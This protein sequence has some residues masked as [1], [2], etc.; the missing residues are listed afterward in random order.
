MLPDIDAIYED[1]H[2]IETEQGAFV[3]P[4]CEKE[5]KRRPAA[6]KHLDK[7]ECHSALDVFEGTPYEE[8]A[9]LFYKN[10]M[11]SSN[12]RARPTMKSFRK[13]RLYKQ[14]NTYILSCIINEVDAGLFYSF[15]EEIIGFRYTNAILSN[16]K[17]DK[18]VHEFRVF[19]HANPSVSGSKEFYKG[20]K[21]ELL[22][23]EDYL[24]RSIAKA[25][26]SIGFI[27]QRKSLEEAVSNFP[28]GY[29]MRILDIMNEVDQSDF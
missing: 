14:V 7:Q 12:S 3:C 22:E 17:D 11:A 13:S 26:I 15:L 6:V 29:R 24:M 16:G 10:I 25:H 4:V 21:E 18:W 1:K 5:Y 9:F 28:V 19:L 8:R 20:Y 23:D 27:Q 2:I